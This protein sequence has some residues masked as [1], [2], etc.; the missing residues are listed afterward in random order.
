MRQFLILFL[1]IPL[2]FYSQNWETQFLHSIHRDSSIQKDISFQFLSRTPAPLGVAFPISLTATAWINKDD[3]MFRQGL[4]SCFAFGF[5]NSIS[6]ILKNTV[7]RERPF[8]AYPQ[9]FRKKAKAGELSFPS[10]HTT[11]AFATATSMALTYKKWYV[12]L[13]AFAWAGGVAVSRM[14]LG[15]HYP[16]DLLGG[17]IIGVGSSFLTWKID[18]YLMRKQR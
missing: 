7:K 3:F 15:V 8:H 9:L 4:R 17:M 11:A 2:G 5:A 16:S 1:F 18:E 14:Y 10:G 13:P 12:T 6:L